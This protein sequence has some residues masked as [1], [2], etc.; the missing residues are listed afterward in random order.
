M[1]MPAVLRLILVTAWCLAIYRGSIALLGFLGFAKAPKEI[2]LQFLSLGIVSFFAS[3]Y[4]ACVIWCFRTRPRHAFAIV[5]MYPLFG[6]L[7]FIA[8]NTFA[9]YGIYPPRV[10]IPAE[11]L[12]GAALA[13]VLRYVWFLGLFFWVM[14]SRVSR[15]FMSQSSTR[16][17]APAAPN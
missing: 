7:L 17:V 2:G 15:H 13:D 6:I 12:A 1:K 4:A 14:R 5:A 10:E 11:Q 3:S 9:M 8:E 16:F